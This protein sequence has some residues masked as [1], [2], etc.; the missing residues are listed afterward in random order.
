MTEGSNPVGLAAYK[1]ANSDVR[2]VH[3]LLVDRTLATCDAARVTD[4][5]LSAVEIVARDDH[6]LCLMFLIC[7]AV[8]LPP[9]EQRGYT[10]IVADPCGAWVQKKLDRL[11][12]AS[13]RAG[14]PN[15]AT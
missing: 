9:F 13:T 6:I 4:A 1:R 14:H 2:V 10:P 5:M 7:G 8:A 12:G 11:G 15:E 3:E